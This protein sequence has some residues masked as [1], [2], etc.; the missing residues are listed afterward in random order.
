MPLIVPVVEAVC[1]ADV[2]A[3]GVVDEVLLLVVAPGN[4]LPLTIGTDVVPVAPIV[5]SVGFAVPV[6]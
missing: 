3:A 4:K 1:K 2:A 6:A 5:A